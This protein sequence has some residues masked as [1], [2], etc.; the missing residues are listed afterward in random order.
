MLRFSANSVDPKHVVERLSAAQL[1]LRSRLNQRGVVNEPLFLSLPV[2]RVGARMQTPCLVS[3]E[4][5][6]QLSK[7]MIM[8]ISVSSPDHCTRSHRFKVHRPP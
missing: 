1:L 6:G 2:E 8:R 3:T 5:L 4:M 7:R